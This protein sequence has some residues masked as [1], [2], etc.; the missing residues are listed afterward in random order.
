VNLI[1]KRHG[2]VI[3]FLLYNTLIHSIRREAI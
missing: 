1:T 2:R 3:Q